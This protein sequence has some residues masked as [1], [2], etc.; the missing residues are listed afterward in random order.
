MVPA[1]SA[2]VAVE[3]SASD[4]SVIYIAGVS[5]T[6]KRAAVALSATG[7]AVAAVTGKKVRV[8]FAWLTGNGAVNVKWQSATT[9]LTGLEYIDAAGKGMVLPPNPYGWCETASAEALNLNLSA[10]VAV[11]GLVGYVEV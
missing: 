5:Y 7:A 9:D 10:S 1:T 2:G 4:D 3:P 6:V 8:I 11:G